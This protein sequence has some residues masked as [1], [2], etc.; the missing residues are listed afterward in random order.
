MAGQQ[1]PSPPFGTETAHHFAWRTEGRNARSA[2]VLV[3]ST[4]LRYRNTNSLSQCLQ[5]RFCISF[6]LILPNLAGFLNLDEWI[7]NVYSVDNHAFKTKHRLPDRERIGL[8]ITP[9]KLWITHPHLWKNF[10]IKRIKRID[11]C[12]ITMYH[13]YMNVSSCIHISGR[14]AFL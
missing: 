14:S 5:Y 12:Q 10:H 11:T 9:L 3:G 7:Q 8:W 13:K 6:A 4:S 2:T 1:L